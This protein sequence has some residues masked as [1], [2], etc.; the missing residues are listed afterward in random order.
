M[1]AVFALQLIPN[2]GARSRGDLFSVS[3][4]F[5][6]RVWGSETP[7]LAPDEKLK[8]ELMAWSKDGICEKPTGHCEEPDCARRST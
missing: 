3:L 8:L 5:F 4:E 6:V 2:Q 1:T 7:M